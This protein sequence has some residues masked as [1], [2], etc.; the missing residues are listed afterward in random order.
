MIITI[1]H[2]EWL[3]SFSLACLL[4]CHTLDSHS[5]NSKMLLGFASPR[6][7]K[8]LFNGRESIAKKKITIIIWAIKCIF[9][10]ILRERVRLSRRRRNNFFIFFCSMLNIKTSDK[11]AFLTL[12]SHSF[13]ALL[14]SSLSH[15][16]HSFQFLLVLL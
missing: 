4:A 11:I 15:F 6:S 14:L 8:L 16:L 13:E 9:H 5:L 3:L 1:K 2:S 7:I 12:F 10:L